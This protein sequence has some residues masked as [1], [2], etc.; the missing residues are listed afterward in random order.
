MGG[1]SSKFAVTNWDLAEGGIKSEKETIDASKPVSEHSIIILNKHTTLNQREY[2][3][4]DYQGDILYST[5]AVEGKVKWFDLFGK[6]GQHICR[7]QTTDIT[8]KHWDIYRYKTPS[9]EGQQSDIEATNN[10][11]AEL[12]KKARVEILWDRYHGDIFLYGPPN[13]EGA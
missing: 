2:D 6:E 3:I 10:A 13:T 9:F 1:G 8:H 7:I 11:G 12:Y 5:K 4:C